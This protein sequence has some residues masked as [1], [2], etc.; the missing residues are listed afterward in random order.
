MVVVGVCLVP[1]SF[2][3]FWDSWGNIIT[4]AVFSLFYFKDKRS[5]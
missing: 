3:F 5:I 1:Y 4:F 2:S